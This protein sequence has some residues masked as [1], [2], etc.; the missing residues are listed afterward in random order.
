MAE[1]SDLPDDPDDTIRVRRRR[2][3]PETAPDE[4][5]RRRD[6][7]VAPDHVDETVISGRTSPP[8]ERPD[9]LDD[10][11]VSRRRR[12]AVVVDDDAEITAASERRGR[13]AGERDAAVPQR[14]A[15]ASGD[16]ERT[17]VSRRRTR[18][19][20]DEPGVIGVDDVEQA[21]RLGAASDETIVTRHRSAEV[22]R[23]TQSRPAADRTPAEA[24]RS[25][26]AR[27]ATPDAATPDTAAPERAATDGAPER[28]IYR[29]RPAEPVRAERAP[30]PGRPP[31]GVPRA[32]PIPSVR[33][34]RRTALALAG[35]VVGVVVAGAA[36]LALLLGIPPGP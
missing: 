5:G 18:G 31:G 32:V 14:S 12:T 6:T 8:R 16:L 33:G 28:A 10:T 19:L 24:P 34:R 25:A 26:A 15:P 7:Y 35:I 20:A 2:S 3:A 22:R 11:A 30:E 1:V 29:P 4:P 13:D 17:A 23:R 36:A 9:D 21:L 27:Q